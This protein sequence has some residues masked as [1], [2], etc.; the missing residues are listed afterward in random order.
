MEKNRSF[1][2]SILIFAA[3]ALIVLTRLPGLMHN[4]SL[5]PDEPVFYN[6]ARNLALFLTGQADSYVPTKFYPEGGFSLHTPFQ[7]LKLLFGS[8]DT[9]GRFVGRLAGC[10]YFLLGTAMGLKLLRRFFTK[11]PAASAV[12]LATM[13]FGLMHIEQSRYATGDTAS[14]FFLMVLLYFSAKG[15]ETEKLRYFLLAAAACG[16]LTSIKYPLIFFLL[17]PY[18]G[19]RKVFSGGGKKALSRGTWKAAGCFLL[20]FLLLSP[21]TLT[22]PTFLFWTAAHETHNYMAGTN[23]TEVGGP[24]NHLISVVLY[25]LLYSGVP[26]LTGMTIWQVGRRV[27]A[28]KHAQGCEYLFQFLIPLV[29]AG[30]F[31]YNL[32]VTAVFMRTYYPFFVIIDLYCAALCGKWL[33]QRGGK[34]IAVIAVC[35]IM[36]L[37]GGYYLYIL[38]VD[39]GVTT[40]QEIISTIPENQYSSI[41]ELKPGKMAFDQMDLPQKDFQAMDLKEERFA[42]PEG[43]ELR[44]GE[45]LIST[46]QEYGVGTPYYLPIF[47]KTVQN[48]IDRWAAFKEINRDYQVGR[49][50]PDHYYTLFGF[51]IK[52]ATGMYLEFPCNVFYLRPIE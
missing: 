9:D 26:L 43:M 20:G 32:F 16:V 10:F 38:G 18:F 3:I 23:L 6:S 46:Y 13:L 36:A 7:L 27:P 44:E 50:Y 1:K 8:S 15:M 21:K 24:V 37:R 34:Q 45:L 51:W 49:L 19:F 41:T 22:D 52:G 17:I 35:L 39:S 25:T 48:Y 33:R 11:D 42:T 14:F 31:V 47:H 29:T 4:A 2:R 28:A 30:F 40:M 12:Y 5:H